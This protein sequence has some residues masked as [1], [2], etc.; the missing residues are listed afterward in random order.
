M[1]ALDEASA[2]DNSSTYS[3]VECLGELD[4]A[5]IE[6]LIEVANTRLP[7]LILLELQQLGGALTRDD[8]DGAAYTAPKAPFYFKIVSPTLKASLEE[9][10]LVTK[11]VVR[12]FG[13]IFTGELSYN[14]MRGDQQ[15][16]VPIVFGAGKYHRLQQIKHKY[17]PGNFFHLNLNIPPSE[18]RGKL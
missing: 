10:A 8:D 6:A 18:S 1:A 9:L 7:P 11:E 15:P 3:H 14:W 13:L 17:D 4:D 2:E 12:S 16:K 5:V